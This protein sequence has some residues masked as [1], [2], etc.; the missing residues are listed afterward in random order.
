M[1]IQK[2]IENFLNHDI[3]AGILGLLVILYASKTQ[4]TLPIQVR[5]L[6]NSDIFRVIFMSLLAIIGGKA[7]PHVALSMAIIFVLTLHYIDMNQIKEHMTKTLPTHTAAHT[8]TH[9]ATHTAAHTATHTATSSNLPQKITTCREPSFKKPAYISYYAQCMKSKN[10]A[11]SDQAC[12]KKCICGANM[13]NSS[14]YN[15]TATCQ[16][17]CDSKPCI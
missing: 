2:S 7:E 16:S 6:F 8:T 9:T 11:S 3:V 10:C 17:T 5:A 4:I 12:K 1:P 15:P 14:T 13:C